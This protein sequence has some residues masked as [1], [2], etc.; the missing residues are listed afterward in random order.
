MLL[1]PDMAASRGWPFIF[2][3]ELIQI[4]WNLSM[5]PSSRCQHPLQTGM[6]A[7]INATVMETSWEQTGLLIGANPGRG[8]EPA[9]VLK[10]TGASLKEPEVLLLIKVP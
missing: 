2:H 6:T 5:S 9:V 8:D 4:P 7:T 3:A 1:L 10:N